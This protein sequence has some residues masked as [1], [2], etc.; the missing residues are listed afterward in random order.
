L[1]STSGSGSGAVESS[2]SRQGFAD[3]ISAGDTKSH[4]FDSA[5]PRART[6]AHVQAHARARAHE[7]HGFVHA[8]AAVC[9]C[10][11]T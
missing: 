11:R 9:A 7:H 5:S 4:L 1:S 6:H 2:R 10:A 3:A 8:C